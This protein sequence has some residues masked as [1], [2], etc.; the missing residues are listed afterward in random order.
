[1]KSS[2]QTTLWI[3]FIAQLLS[4]M[5]FS[6]TFP[7]LP[8]YVAELGSA[9]GTSV[10]FWTGMAFSS[11]AVTMAIASPIWGSLADRLGHKLMV[12]RAM[13]GGALLLLLMGF[14]RSAEELVLLRLIQGGVTGTIA[15]ANAMLAA[16]APRERLG[17]AMGTLQMGLW[18]G[19]AAGPLLG[20]VLADLL[21]FRAPFYLTAVLLL[22]SGLLV[23]LGVRGGRPQRRGERARQ[24]MLA[25]WQAIF[26]APSVRLTYSLR[27]L[28]SLGL[29]MLLPFIPLFIQGLMT[30]D[31]PIG[32]FTG[33]VVGA[34][35]AAGTATAIYFG[36]LGDRTSHRRVLIGCALASAICYLPQGAVWEPWQLLA[37]QAMSGAAWG[38]VTPALSALLVRYTGSGSEGVVYGLDNAIVSAARAAAPLLGAGVVLAFGLRGI[39]VLTAAIYGVVALLATM[40]LPEPRPIATPA[41]RA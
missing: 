7:F 21:G 18:S 2:W 25:S 24:G 16:I 32:T 37:L 26:A 27:F 31:A 19:T 35:S 30:G 3:M 15:A 13:Y 23:T 33:L 36:R 10:E 12:E 28:S 39:F 17:F 20:G 29:S 41:E 8:L 14:V 40:S 1:M 5:G 4:A 11:Q 6:V 9:T 38:G 22:V 34:S